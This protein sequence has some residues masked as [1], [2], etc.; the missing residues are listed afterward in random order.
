MKKVWKWVIGIVIGLVVLSALV[1]GAFL[2]RSHFVNVVTFGVNRP[3]IQV[4]GYGWDERQGG[5]RYP[6][7]M[8]FGIHG[9]GGSMGMRGFGMMGSVRRIDRRPVSAWVFWRWLCWVSSGWLDGCANQRW[10]RHRLKRL[11]P[12]HP[13]RLLRRSH[14]PARVVANLSMKN[15]NIVR[16]A[17]RNYSRT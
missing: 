7:M 4:P 13:Q 3:G 15:G 9:W 16:I 2:L 12:L 1:A 10:L 17:A 5:G 11:H 6:G 8:P 14:I